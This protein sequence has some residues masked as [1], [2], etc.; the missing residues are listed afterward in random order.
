MMTLSESASK[1]LSLNLRKSENVV[2]LDLKGPIFIG[3]GAD[4]LAA[5]IKKLIVEGNRCIAID[6]TEVTKVDSSGMGALVHGHSSARNAGGRIK[7]YGVGE[8]VMMILKMVRL[9]TVFEMY[10][11][12]AAALA[13]F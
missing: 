2:I 1:R 12:E 8:H 7:L 11:D 6:M 13:S 3:E 5:Q 4:L 10:E 9:D